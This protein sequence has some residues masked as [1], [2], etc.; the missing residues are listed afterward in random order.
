[1][2]FHYRMAGIGIKQSKEKTWIGTFGSITNYSFVG[3]DNLDTPR[4]TF[5]QT[6]KKEGK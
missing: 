6:C 4:F 5:G 3:K 1:M 2:G